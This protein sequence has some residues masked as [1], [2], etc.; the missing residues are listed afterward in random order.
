MNFKD[1][2][3]LKYTTVS[4]T[5]GP[6]NNKNPKGPPQPHAELRCLEFEQTTHSE[7]R[8]EHFGNFVSIP[9][10]KNENNNFM[11]ECSFKIHLFLLVS[12]VNLSSHMNTE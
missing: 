12:D 2:L 3:F 4:L 9:H 6:Y 5:T 8:N 7:N 11:F 1:A 10:K